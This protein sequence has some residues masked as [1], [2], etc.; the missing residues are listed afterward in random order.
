[1]SGLLLRRVEL[2]LDRVE[3]LL[4]RR[5]ELLDALVLEHLEDVGEVDADALQGV[6]VLLEGVGAGQAAGDGVDVDPLQAAGQLGVRVPTIGT[7]LVR[8]R[9]YLRTAVQKRLAAGSRLSRYLS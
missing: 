2:S 4:P 5:L 6:V 3:Q 9:A 7:R 8:A 1:M